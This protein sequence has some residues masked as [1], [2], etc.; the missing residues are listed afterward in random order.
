MNVPVLNLE[1]TFNDDVFSCGK[2]KTLRECQVDRYERQ[3]H[4]APESDG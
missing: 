2:Y 4:W 1:E 3:I